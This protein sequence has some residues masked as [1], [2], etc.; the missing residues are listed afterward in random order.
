MRLPRKTGHRALVERATLEVEKG[1]LF[2]SIDHLCRQRC[3]NDALDLLNASLEVADD[4]SWVDL[5]IRAAAIEHEYLHQLEAALDRYES[6]LD[7][8]PTHGVA[9]SAVRSLL[10]HKATRERS[11]DLLESV[12]RSQADWPRLAALLDHRAQWADRNTCC[13]LLR[14][15]SQIYRDRLSDVNKAFDTQRRILTVNP[16]AADSLDLLKQLEEDAANTGRWAEFVDTIE[17]LAGSSSGRSNASATYHLMA[18]EACRLHLHD[19]RRAIS[20]YRA[21]ADGGIG[22]KGAYEALE[23]L[24]RETGQWAEYGDL[25]ERRADAK[26][27]CL[28]KAKLLAEAGRV[29]FKK[30]HAPDRAIYCFERLYQI[31]TTPHS[32]TDGNDDISLLIDEAER[33]LLELYARCERWDDFAN[34]AERRAFCRTTTEQSVELLLKVAKVREEQLDDKLD[35]LDCYRKILAIDS[36][37]AE[38]IAA[39]ERCMVEAVFQDDAAAILEPLFATKQRWHDLAGIYRRQLRA[40]ADVDVQLK[41]KM[42]IAKLYEEHLHDLSQAFEWYG[43]VFQQAPKDSATCDHLVQLARQLDCWDRLAEHLSS[44]LFNLAHD[45]EQPEEPHE[46]LLLLARIYDERLDQ[47]EEAEHCLRRILQTSPNDEATFSLLESLLT[48]NRQWQ[49]LT[50]LYAEVAN[51]SFSRERRC[52]LLLRRARILS[53]VLGDKGKACVAFENL[54]RDFPTND[55]IL[56]SLTELYERDERWDDLQSLLAYTAKKLVEKGEAKSRV[57]NLWFRQGEIHETALD[58]YSAALDAYEQAIDLDNHHQGAVAALERLIVDREHRPRILDLLEQV[59]R[60]QGQWA[61]LIVICEAQLDNETAQD[62]QVKYLDEVARLYE[63][64]TNNPELALDTI[65]KLF[66]V[67]GCSDEASLRRLPALE[68]LCRKTG[69]W[70]LAL[71]QLEAT[72]EQQPDSAATP[73]LWRWLARIREQELADHA[74]ATDA[75]RRVLAS[76]AADRTALIELDRLYTITDQFSDLAY[77]LQH[78]IRIERA[79][80]IRTELFRRLAQLAENHLDD[81]NLAIDAWAQLLAYS[82]MDIEAL[83]ALERLYSREERWAD[84]V[85][86]C[87]RQIDLTHALAERR[88]I[89]CRI[90]RIYQT[91]LR[92]RRKTIAVYRELLDE[93][94]GDRETL[95]ALESLYTEEAD[96]ESA[97][98]VVE[99]KL[100]LP[101]PQDEQNALRSRLVE[102]AADRLQDGSLAL[103]H[104]RTLLHHEPHHPTGREVGHRLLKSESTWRGAADLLELFYE[105]HEDRNQLIAVL[106]ARA[107]WLAGYDDLA[108]ECHEVYFRIGELREQVLPEQS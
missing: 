21:A 27:S 63:E 37:N 44:V 82:D 57:A 66:R 90:A 26:H 81:T 4:A 52:D 42:R 94:P 67:D 22:D 83:A 69:R 80:A 40:S 49:A 8:Q 39:V 51:R 56:Q 68:R 102:I 20:H 10:R 7:R 86:I 78:R 93:V 104:L 60:R 13:K 71:E 6:V 103:V 76:H 3:W 18:A 53:D 17:V 95:D 2:G 5:S 79:P 107:S 85:D 28:D 43:Q 77:V 19:H 65:C 16:A 29:F 100:S 92:D 54:H 23:L 88:P 98:E 41:L 101:L 32:R 50:E 96:W 33:S 36:D 31:D 74:A 55:D 15:A 11:A 61:K 25:L 1:N 89:Y 59:Y 9:L 47:W 35:A 106:E 48:R 75:W 58:N 70:D 73:D 24:Y 45:A 12:Y 105:R 64:R 84:T 14:E 72:L 34:C 87:R 91:R 30:L 46:L 38:A 97:F 99:Q 108:Q 62:Q